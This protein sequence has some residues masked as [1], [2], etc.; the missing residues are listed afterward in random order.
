MENR[1]LKALK[2]RD[3]ETKSVFIITCWNWLQD[4]KIL[5]PNTIRVNL[6]FSKWSK[7][8]SLTR[9]LGIALQCVEI[10]NGDMSN[11]LPIRFRAYWK[12]N[13]SFY[14]QV[15]GREKPALCFPSAPYELRKFVLNDPYPLPEK[16]NHS[17]QDH[18]D[19]DSI[20]FFMIQ[21][22]TDFDLFFFR[23]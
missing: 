10:L 22:F 1:K 13:R 6:T 9:R 4:M 18:S 17:D 5:E 23:E 2:I 3:N 16:Q 14:D 12:N 15:F 8:H 11:K 20:S 7:P 21:Y 19:K